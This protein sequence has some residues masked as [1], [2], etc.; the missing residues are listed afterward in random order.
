[1]KNLNIKAIAKAIVYKNSL[2]KTIVLFFWKRKFAYSYYNKKLSLINKWAIKD[3]ELSNFYY[4]L[5]ELNK[6]YLA[7]TISIITGVS[8]DQIYTYFNELLKDKEL[9]TSI[10]NSLKQI[11]EYGKDIKFAY[12]RRIGWYAFTRILKPKLLVET[13]VDHGIGSCVL[14][15]ALLRNKAEGFEGKYIGTDINPNAGRLLVE[16]Y[17][18]IGEI[19]YGD[20]LESLAAIENNIDLFINDS[21]H[22]AEYEYSEYLQIQQKLSRESIILGDNSHVTDCLSRFSKK[23]NRSFL[24]FQEKPKNHWYPGAGIGISF[25]KN[26]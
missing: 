12:G 19:I 22:S 11:S 14:T 23:L 20:S 4:D 25:N 7:N 1:M 26:I 8:Y 3:N 16:P 10:N 24:F 18:S 13:G 17:S 5:E 9:F 15:S 6:D 2:I 21:D